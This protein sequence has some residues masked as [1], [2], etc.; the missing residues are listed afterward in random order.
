MVK[1]SKNVVLINP[2][3]AL[4]EMSLQIF[5]QR[6]KIIEELKGK[7][8]KVKTKQGM[9]TAI[10]LDADMTHF[11]VKIGGKNKKM[12]LNSIRQT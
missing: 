6:Q 12:K 11:I 8:I 9:V 4:Q 1:I 3:L 5:K 7:Q 10:F 2:E